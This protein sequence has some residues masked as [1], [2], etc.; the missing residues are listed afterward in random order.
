MPRQYQR[1]IRVGVSTCLLGQKV[2]FDGGHKHDRFLTESLGRFVRFVPICPELEVGMGVPRE[3]VRLVGD[4]ESPRM[5]GNKSGEDW[6]ERMTD[7]C[8]KR[9][10]RK[11]IQALCGYI[12]KRKS[13]SCGMERVKVYSEESGMPTS[14]GVG[15]FAAELMRAHPYL[16]VE[17]EGRLTE[18]W[19]RD[20]FV[21]RVF[22][23]YRWR[24]LNRQPFSRQRMI[25]FHTHHKYLLLAHNPQMYRE[26]GRLVAA[27]KSIPPAQFREQY[28]DQFMRTLSYRATTK[29]NV[30]VLHHIVG[31]IKKQ[32]SADEKRDVLQAIEDYQ[33]E[34]V[35]L[36][37]PIT[38]IRHFIRKYG[39]DYILAQVYLSPHPKELMLRNHM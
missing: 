1:Q 17:E 30:N 2:R 13:P 12:L 24:E 20:N 37:V 14:P 35:P 16:P 29:K 33:A 18:P 10:Q 38:L 19:L 9:V 36:I 7:Y 31:F 21:V 6:T 34:L 8:R 11:D 32:M 3:A 15:L 25:E 22:A 23:L 4:P 5:V 39:I 28:L 26:L 27:I